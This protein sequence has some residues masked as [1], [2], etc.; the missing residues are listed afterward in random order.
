MSQ[1]TGQDQEAA[2]SD[3]R[4]KDPMDGSEISGIL[5]Q[6]LKEATRLGQQGAATKKALLLAIAAAAKIGQPSGETEAEEVRGHAEK[7]EEA[8]RAVAKVAPKPQAS[9]PR[10]CRL[11][12]R[13]CKESHT[14]DKCGVFSKMPPD[15]KLF[16]LKE[17]R[18]CLF[19]YKH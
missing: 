6:A 3:P 1:Q 9:G 11:A 19:C 18:L 17:N 7:K 14:M 16:V 12:D 8:R 2:R 13:G 10:P 5:F 4:I 15:W